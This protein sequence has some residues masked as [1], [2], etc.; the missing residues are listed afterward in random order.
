MKKLLFSVLI[1]LPSLLFSQ[2]GIGTNTPDTSAKLE[3]NSTNKGFLPPRVTLTGTTDLATIT[4]PATGLLIYNTS[5]AGTSPNNVSPGFYF[6]N[7]TSW[8][9]L[10]EA[11]DNAT[12][13][14]GT[15][16]VANGGTG[17]TNGSITGTSSLTF[18]SGGTNQNLTLTPSGSG[19]TILNGNV[20]I[21]SSDPSSTLEV[22]NSTG[23]VS[24]V[25]NINPQN[26]TD[27]GGQITLMK[28]VSGF[29]LDWTIDQ[30]SNSSN[31]RFRIFPGT[32]ESKGLT[33]NELGN[34]G[35]GVNTQNQTEKLYVNGATKIN[36]NLN[37][38]GGYFV[39]GALSSDQDITNSNQNINFS[40]V[41]DLNNWWDSTSKKFQPTVAGNYYVSLQVAFKPMTTYASLQNN[42]QIRRNGN[43]QSIAQ[44]E[45]PGGSI[46]RTMYGTGIVYMN[47]T[48]DYI[49]FT[50][51]SSSTTA[52]KIV[53]DG[54][55]SWTKFEAFK[56][57]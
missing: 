44:N 41:S 49:D 45:I 10:N 1:I 40:D 28:S 18:A 21:G 46:N 20:G 26:T 25:I 31:P 9:K 13:V 39:K 19:K 15:V 51:Y 14:T 33:L 16:A 35:I 24:G 47:G 53:G 36:E 3:V 29:T 7:G 27:E 55:N 42:I 34:V 52:Q 38:N 50:T 6:F 48:T 2:V 30:I 32:D 17:T 43:T 8:S 5:T 56:L 37:A 57:N 11:S 22:G 54:T 23:T 12:N 4:S